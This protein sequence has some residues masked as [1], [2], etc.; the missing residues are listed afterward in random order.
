MISLH[1]MCTLALFHFVS[2]LTDF[3]FCSCF[4]ESEN[5]MIF[6]IYM[7]H[8]SSLA[9]YTFRPPAS[10]NW[11]ARYCKFIHPFLFPFLN[12]ILIH[13]L[14]PKDLNTFAQQGFGKSEISFD[15]D[16]KSEN[17][18]AFYTQKCHAFYVFSH[19]HINIIT[20]KYQSF[21]RSP[22]VN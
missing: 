17:F 2:F 22:A 19:N 5:D 9:D 10:L 12:S 11:N 1:L 14:Y 3:C 7:S 6:C 21:F 13:K 15:S 4:E 18:L 16:S 20:K 8:W